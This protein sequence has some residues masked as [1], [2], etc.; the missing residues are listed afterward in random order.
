MKNILKT[1]LVMFVFVLAVGRAEAQGQ[2]M[3]LDMAIVSVA[4]NLTGALDR[5]TRIAVLPIESQSVQM[6]HFLTD[7]LIIQLVNM[8]GFVVTETAVGARFVIS[9]N[10]VPVAG[11]HLFTA[12]VVDTSNNAILRIFTV[13]IQHDANVAALLGGAAGQAPIAVVAQ[14]PREPPPPREP[15]PA[16]EPSPPRSIF[17]LGLGGNFSAHWNSFSVIAE[18]LG[19][20]DTSSMLI[21]GGVSAFFDATFVEASVGLLFGGVTQSFEYSGIFSVVGD[22]PE[23]RETYLTLGLLG[24]FPIDMGNFTIFPML[25]IQYDIGLGMTW[26]GEDVFEDSSDRSDAMNRFW[27]RIGAGAD[28]DLSDALFFRT[29]LLWGINFGSRNLRE[30]LDLSNEIPGWSARS[31]H[32]GLDIRLALGLSW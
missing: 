17:A 20:F 24:R 4:S 14:P 21:G 32:H 25:G 3:N 2:V 5:G 10:V 7:G 22:T 15:R 31:F 9:G 16:R 12:Q 8:Q 23:I 28:F 27:I 13:N 29:S 18:D 1:M 6:T 11:N 19:A 30:M 26:E